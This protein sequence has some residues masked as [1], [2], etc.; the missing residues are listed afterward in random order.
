MNEGNHSPGYQKLARDLL[1][2]INAGIGHIPLGKLKPHHIQT[3]YKN[4]SEDGIKNIDPVAVSDKLAALLK[5]RK[6]SRA[7]VGELA[8]VSAVTV[9]TACQGKNVKLETA[10]KIAKALDMDVE[11]LFEITKKK[12][13]LADQTLKRYYNLVS[14]I[15]GAAVQMQAIP[16]NPALRVIKPKGRK[17]E[18][19]YLDDRQALQVLEALESAP[20]KWRTAMMLLLHTGMRKGE[21]CGL[22]WGDIDFENHLVDINKANQYLPNKG[23][24]EKDTKNSSSDRILKLHVSMFDLLAKYKEWQDEEKQKMGDLWHNS[25]KLFTQKDGLPIHPTS[26]TGWVRDFRVANNLPKFTPHTLRHTSATLLIMEGVPVKAVSARLGHASQSTTNDVYS[27]TIQTAEAMASDVIGEFLTKKKP[28]DS[29]LTP[30][31][32]K[33]SQRDQKPHKTAGGD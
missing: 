33:T 16:E 31:L 20:L 19:A 8:G 17:K 21:L 13:G 32:T 30:D 15:L 5:E 14:A 7:A 25:G 4:L 3:F 27:H 9:T 6:L 29:D 12:E 10:Q 11:K 28:G 1:V 23:I 2:R 18:A 26:V 24:F 22:T